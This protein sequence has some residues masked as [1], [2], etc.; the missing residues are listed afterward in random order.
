MV[1][2]LHVMNRVRFDDI[3]IEGDK[4]YGERIYC[5]YE[6]RTEWLTVFWHQLKYQ[7][8]GEHDLQ[9]KKSLNEKAYTLDFQSHAEYAQKW[10]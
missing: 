7:S 1:S 5:I 3:E 6:G 2:Y 4:C 10:G 9:M 8:V